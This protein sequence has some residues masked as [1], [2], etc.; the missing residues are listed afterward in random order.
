M[1]DHVTALISDWQCKAEVMQH[2][3]DYETVRVMQKHNE[4]ITL[5]AVYMRFSV[6]LNSPE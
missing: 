5:L 1:C 4:I 6:S 3:A 2:T